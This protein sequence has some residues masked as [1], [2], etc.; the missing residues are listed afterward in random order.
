[1]NDQIPRKTCS[2]HRVEGLHAPDCPLYDGNNA[3]CGLC[4]EPMSESEQMFRYHGYSGSCPKP[5]LPRADVPTP[6]PA[7]DFEAAMKAALVKGSPQSGLDMTFDVRRMFPVLNAQFRSALA[8]RD[9]QLAEAVEALEHI[10]RRADQWRECQDV[11][12]STL[13][14]LRSR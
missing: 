6:L 7:L 9:A 2:C 3:K 13:A 8:A 5:A 11:A 4:G 10:E 12:T 1:M 14:R